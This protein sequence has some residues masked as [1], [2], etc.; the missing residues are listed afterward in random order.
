MDGGS[1][2]K[3]SGDGFLWNAIGNLQA[4]RAMIMFVWKTCNNI[5][6]MKDNLL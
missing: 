2:S 4:P 5:L 3:P 1:N 6:A